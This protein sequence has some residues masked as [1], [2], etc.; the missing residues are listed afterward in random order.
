MSGSIPALSFGQADNPGDGRVQPVEKAAVSVLWHVRAS[1]WGRPGPV[2]LFRVSGLADDG[3]FSSGGD[4]GAPKKCLWGGEV[5][6]QVLGFG[7]G[8]GFCWPGMFTE[9]RFT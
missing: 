5:A 7:L 4:K 1:T 8:A 9:F 2:A 6:V 3:D